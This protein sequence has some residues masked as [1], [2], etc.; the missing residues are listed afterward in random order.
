MAKQTIW[1]VTA[2]GS[3]AR[4]IEQ[5]TPSEDL[6]LKEELA[7]ADAHL[8]TRELVSDR[9]G[10]G[11]ESGNPTHH[12]MPSRHDPHQLQKSAFLRTVA[13]R[14]NKAASEGEYDVLVL[15][16][17]PRALGELRRELSAPA[18]RRLKAAS[19]K[20]LTKVALKALPKHLTALPALRR[21]SA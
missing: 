19:S 4:I 17:A 8:L 12:A 5:L 14:L 11:Q 18:R 3:R 13:E 16:A 7:S 21:R 6:T 1:I 10:R 9:P 2:D 15:F 20:D